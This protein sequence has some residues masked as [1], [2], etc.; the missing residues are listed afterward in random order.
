[1]RGLMTTEY[2]RQ[3]LVEQG[4]H[5]DQKLSPP[6]GDLE[7]DMNG[8]EKQMVADMSMVIC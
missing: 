6:F 8:Y 1:M 5:T 2:L 4:Q 3:F 7:V